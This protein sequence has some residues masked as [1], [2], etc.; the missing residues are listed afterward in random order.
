MKSQIASL[1]VCY[2]S[3]AMLG[4]TVN[5]LNF[6]AL[7]AWRSIHSRS[8][9]SLATILVVGLALGFFVVVAVLSDGARRGITEASDPFGTLV[10]GPNGDA[11]QLVL[12]TILLSGNPLGTI[13]VEIY[14]SLAQDERAELTIP[15][16][17]A[18]NVGG[19]RVIGTT[20][21][22]FTL[23]PA[24][25]VAS[26]FQLADGRFF[27]DAPFDDITYQAEVDDVEA[28][29]GFTAA[30][31]LGLVI[32]DQFVT[33][34]GATPVLNSDLH[35]LPHTVV[36]ILQQTNTAF[37][38]GVFVPLAS[39]WQTHADF[40]VGLP[41]PNIAREPDTAASDV[42]ELTAILVKPKGV[43]DANVLWQEFYGRDDAQAAFPGQELGRLL[44]TFRQ[45][46]EIL[47][48]VGYLAAIMAGLTIFLAIYNATVDREQMIAVMRGIGSGRS[49][50][51]GMVLLEGLIVALLGAL[52]ARI[53]GYGAAWL[54]ADSL[55]VQNGI[56]IP[57]R[58]VPEVETI[59]WL[60]PIGLGLLAAAIPALLT[61]RLNVVDKLFVT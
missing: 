61:Y 18:D 43:I 14:D 36:G 16:A 20:T 37:D 39:V 32:G 8:I 57:V 33:S 30:Q 25:Q 19:A 51:L 13:D 42:G 15:M 7:L 40:I 49:V 24:L 12:S 26:P 23:Q 9:Q 46:E 45:L 17:M 22:F 60:L 59:L 58:F 55:S 56:P 53:L 31:N 5:Q 28:V 4:K 54:I 21:D 50:V 1:N 47:T 27:E 48:T 29:L 38:S 44:S 2:D 52:L 11:Q 34:H 35:N 41:Q 3:R 10:I 6:A